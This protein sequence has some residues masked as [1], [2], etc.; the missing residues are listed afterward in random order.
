MNE[1]LNALLE[2]DSFV[3][4]LMEAQSPEA[5]EELLLGKN[6]SVSRSEVEAMLKAMM[7]QLSDSDEELDDEDLEMIAGGAATLSTVARAQMRAKE[8]TF[9]RPNR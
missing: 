1:E 5:A 6:V 3:K 4:E 8:M 2:D 7:A 9:Q